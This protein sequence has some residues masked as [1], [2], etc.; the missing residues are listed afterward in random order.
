MSFWSTTTIKERVAAEKLINP[1]LETAAIHCAYELMVS[2]EF[3]VTPEATRQVLSKDQ[4]IVIPPGQ[5]GLLMTTEHVTIPKDTIGLISIRAS[6]KFKGLV[7]VSGFHVD[8]GFSGRLK[9]SV[10]NA[11]SKDIVI[12]PERRIFMIWFCSLDK[13]VEDPYVNRP[14]QN[15]ISDEDVMRMRGQVASPGQLQEEINSIR[16]KINDTERDLEHKFN[17]LKTVRAK[18]DEFQQKLA[19]AQS[20]Q[21]QINRMM[22]ALVGA[23]IVGAA[24]AIWTA[25]RPASQP[26]QSPT[27]HDSGLTTATAPAMPTTSSAPA[28]TTPTVPTVPSAPATTATAA[29]EGRKI[30]ANQADAGAPHQQP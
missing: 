7:N 30:P 10:Y 14:N 17:E 1:Y 15:S 27:T 6:I 11:G 25:L 13:E 18:V 26:P 20:L 24:T 2:P 28:L 19:G 12:D 21:E 3:A 8:P 5:F 23:V 16:A 9:F 29:P 22:W 4:Q